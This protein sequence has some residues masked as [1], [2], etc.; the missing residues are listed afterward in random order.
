MTQSSNRSDLIRTLLDLAKQ[1]QRDYAERELDYLV[2]V[3]PDNPEAW[4]ALAQVSSTR[5]KAVYCLEQVVRIQPGNLAAANALN[6]RPH[7]Q[8]AMSVP[9]ID[10]PVD[11][12]R[13]NVTMGLLTCYTARHE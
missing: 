3:E 13:P 5:Q 4:L 12:K 2:R 7:N 8:C 6:R 10:L 1:G 9:L 11:V